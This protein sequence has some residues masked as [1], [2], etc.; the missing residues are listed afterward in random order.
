MSINRQ[1]RKTLVDLGVAIARLRRF[2]EDRA[3][4]SLQ[5]LTLKILVTQL[6]S[7]EN[8]TRGQVIDAEDTLI[9]FVSNV[10]YPKKGKYDEEAEYL[11]YIGT[12]CQAVE[13]YKQQLTGADL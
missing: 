5:S 1:E 8:Y 2:I 10:S 7:P 4:D 9:R 11:G 12:I 3:E 13:I 6:L